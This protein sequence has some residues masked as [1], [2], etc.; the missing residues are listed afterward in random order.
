MINLLTQVG[1]VLNLR[2]FICQSCGSVVCFKFYTS[3]PIE[4]QIYLPRFVVLRMQRFTYKC[5]NESN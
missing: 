1:L 4:L 2:D 5:H 3:E